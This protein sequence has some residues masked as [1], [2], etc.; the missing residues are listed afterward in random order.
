MTF[1]KLE[2]KTD[3]TCGPMLLNS[4]FVSCRICCVYVGRCWRTILWRYMCRCPASWQ[5]MHIGWWFSIVLLPQLLCMQLLSCEV[6]VYACGLKLSF[7]IFFKDL[8]SYAC[9]INARAAA[10][11]YRIRFCDEFLLNVA[12]DCA[13]F[14]FVR[15]VVFICLQNE[16]FRWL[17]LKKWVTYVFKFIKASC[18]THFGSWLQVYGFNVEFQKLLDCCNLCV[19]SFI[20]THRSNRI[21]SLAL[22]TLLVYI[23]YLLNIWHYINLLLKRTLNSATS[24]YHD[25]VSLKPPISTKLSYWI[26][27]DLSLSD[28][29]YYWSGNML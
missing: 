1:A 16:Q 14:A 12:L 11:L 7:K 27:L 19:H 5:P 10:A 4:L 21:T 18:W 28:R 22:F 15:F 20:I 8:K 6:V 23:Y 29:M 2:I 17:F 24:L 26:R 25:A 9:G 3:L 13:L